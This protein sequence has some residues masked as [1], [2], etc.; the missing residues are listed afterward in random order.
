MSTDAL[1][2]L[3]FGILHLL[4]GDA[5]HTSPVDMAA[6]LPVTDT[7]IRNRIEKLEERGII[8]G[9]VPVIGYEK[10]GF[11]LR[12]KFTCTA[13]VQDRADIAEGALELPNVV[14]VEEMLSA[15]ENIRIL[16]VTNQAEKL[17]EITSRI[18][19]MG[20]TIERESLM[21]RAHNR[22]F[23]HFGENMVTRE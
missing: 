23:N 15:S 3:D 21:R 10:A 2:E 5:R 7:T 12:V 11:Q 16:V 19:A 6:K 9:Y 1:D 17:N 4:Q 20:L 14:H 13:P 22:P 8:E 18:D